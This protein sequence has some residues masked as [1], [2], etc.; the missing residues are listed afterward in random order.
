M[1]SNIKKFYLLFIYLF[2]F[3]LKLLIQSVIKDI[4]YSTLENYIS[5]SR[6]LI[7]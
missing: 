1:V 7:G 2:F 3:S 6:L 5:V 4:L